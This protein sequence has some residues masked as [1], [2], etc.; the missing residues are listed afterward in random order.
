MTSDEHVLDDVVPRRW[1]RYL[2]EVLTAVTPILVGYG[3]ISESDAALW[4]GLVGA[5]LATGAQ[6]ASARNLRN[7]EKRE[8]DAKR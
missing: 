4:T 3:V 5:I 6:A 8:E 1:R 2:R 7:R